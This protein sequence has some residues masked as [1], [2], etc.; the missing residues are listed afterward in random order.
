[1]LVASFEHNSDTVTEATV[2]LCTVVQQIEKGNGIDDSSGHTINDVQSAP[3]P[4]SYLHTPCPSRCNA[5]VLK[6]PAM[7]K[8][9]TG[10]EHGRANNA[11]SPFLQ[12]MDKRD[13]GMLMAA[14][15]TTSTTPDGQTT[16][17]KPD[18]Q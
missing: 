15:S 9:M 7:T 6:K 10:K 13:Y 3:L 8:D 4:N 14:P 12:T 1:L 2:P 18:A 16:A 17:I 11:I 5:R